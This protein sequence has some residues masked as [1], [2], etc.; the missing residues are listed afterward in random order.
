[1][2]LNTKSALCGMYKYSGA[3]Y[4]QEAVV[5]AVRR[6]FMAVLLFHRV[7][8]AIPPDSLTV[9][10]ERFYEICCMLR[11]SF[12]VVPLSEVFRLLKT[13]A[14]VPRRTVAIT[15]DD[16]YQD[17]LFAARLLADLGLPA[18][19]FVP[20]SFVSSNVIFDW[21]KHLPQM[22]NLTWDE[23]RDMADMGFE[24][25]SH[26]VTHA[27][28]AAIPVDQLRCELVESKR[29]LEEKLGQS[30]RWLAYPYGGKN[31]FSLDR[32]PLIQEAGYEGCLSGYGGFVVPHLN[33]AIVPRVPVPDFRSTLHL[34]LYLTGSLQW[35]Y[36][37]K[38]Q[39]GLDP[40]KGPKIDPAPLT[41]ASA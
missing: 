13:K 3:M 40:K 35:L 36:A 41:T 37:L 6:P 33:Q 2:K 21:D 24:I 11:R 7:T 10:T 1:M 9:G 31:N 4:A 29:A 5:R 18:C 8:D 28:L 38:R 16:C 27:D 25:G 15:F 19:F 32:L 17:N 30:V 39:V 14:P 12:N 34:E 26:T 22:A 23:V 20:T